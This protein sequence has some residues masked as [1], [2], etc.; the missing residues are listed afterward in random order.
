MVNLTLGVVRVVIHYVTCIF[1]RMDKHVIH[2]WIRFA[3]A[4]PNNVN[5][6]FSGFYKRYSI[7]FQLLESV[8]R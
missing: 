8:S 5:Q 2:G 7:E 3:V 1:E 4:S 6:V